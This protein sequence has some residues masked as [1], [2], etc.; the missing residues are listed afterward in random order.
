[1]N[2]LAFGASTSST[3]INQ[4]L[5]AY[6]ASLIPQ[7]HVTLLDLNDFEMPIYSE[8]RQVNDGIPPEAHTF[9]D[10]LRA[11]D[12]VI[13]SFSEHN[14]VYTA[15]F[16]NIMDWNSVIEGKAWQNKPFLLMATSPGSRGGSTI[17]D[18]AVAK[19][20]Y[21]GAEIAASFSLPFFNKNFDES[22]GI[23]DQELK[24]QH[25]KAVQAL[26][27]AIPVLADE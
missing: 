4:R 18:I 20:P 5:A 3:S 15:A 7:G 23:T 1:M 25:E 16:K 19:W 2:I 17:L 14:G 9:R 12:G 26:V 13:V 6:T 8:D 22:T 11:A 21:M 27:K 10:H 24:T